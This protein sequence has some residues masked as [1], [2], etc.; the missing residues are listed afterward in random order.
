M[1]FKP[2]RDI[3]IIKLYPHTDKKVAFEGYS[4]NKYGRRSG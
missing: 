1:T 3:D 4:L 2:D